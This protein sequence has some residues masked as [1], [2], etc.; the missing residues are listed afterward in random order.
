MEIERETNLAQLLGTVEEAP[1]F[2]HRSFGEQFY[3]LKLDVT[4][5]R[6]SG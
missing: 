3:E 6:I 4:K 5:K 2:S 1:Q